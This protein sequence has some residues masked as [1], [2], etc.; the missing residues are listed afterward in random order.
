[1]FS[2]MWF[3][4]DVAGIAQVTAGCET[5]YFRKNR[6]QAVGGLPLRQAVVGLQEVDALIIEQR[7]D[8]RATHV[9][10]GSQLSRG[11][12]GRPLGTGSTPPGEPK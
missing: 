12:I 6:Q 8:R 10:S 1:M 4:L 5:M 11:A 9:F 3:G 7:L 2:R